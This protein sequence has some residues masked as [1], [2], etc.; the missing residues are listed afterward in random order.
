MLLLFG[1]PQIHQLAC[2]FIAFAKC[3]RIPGNQACRATTISQV[4]LL[5]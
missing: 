1:K 4:K 2:R 5:Q 3:L